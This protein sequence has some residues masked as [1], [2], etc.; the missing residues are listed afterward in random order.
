M[1]S[2]Y[3]IALFGAGL[4]SAPLRIAPIQHATAHNT[5]SSMSERETRLGSPS[6][7][8]EETDSAGKEPGSSSKKGKKKTYSAI[9][10]RSSV[11]VW[12]VCSFVCVCLCV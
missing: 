9:A 3:Q 5:M 10:V 7:K 12:G 11:Q 1:G 4:Q 2:G 6:E 8:K